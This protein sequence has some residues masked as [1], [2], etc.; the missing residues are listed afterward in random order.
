M[1]IVGG[2]I[3]LV[4]GLQNVFKSKITES[5]L[6]MNQDKSWTFFTKGFLIN[7]MNPNVFFFWFG[8]VMVAINTYH[9]QA[10]FILLHFFLC[11]SGGIQHRL[12]KGVCSLFASSSHSREYTLVSQ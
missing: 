7:S 5:H 12:F 9:N 8:A 4:L 3:L 2:L 11:I 10:S 6:A 1:Y